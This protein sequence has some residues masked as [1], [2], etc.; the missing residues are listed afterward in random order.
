MSKKGDFMKQ[1]HDLRTI[2][3]EAKRI[4]FFGGAGVSKGS[5]IPDFRGTGG[6][7]T[8]GGYSESP[9]EMLSSTYL[10][11]YP[12]KFF[13]YYKNN[14]LYP[15]AKPNAA[16]LTLAK[17][18]RE[19][20]LTSVITQ[21]VDGLHQMAGSKNVIE[22]H[23]SVLRNYC[24]SCGEV[25]PLSHILESDGIPRCRLCGA[26]V[27]PD[28]VLYGEN[29]DGAAFMQAQEDIACADVLI[30][31]GTSLTVYPAAGLVQHFRGEH[32][33][34]INQT[35]TPYD[36]YAEIIIREPIEKVLADL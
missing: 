12:E 13:A 8:Q 28:V 15:D 22:L 27:R 10:K 36:S 26:V 5:G 23:G 4:V 14:M 24:V 33:I 2:I 18:E 29:L 17:W 21:N 34:I 35:R 19:G 32:F 20:K 7:Y 1:E 6:L 30:V 16:H 11:R 25:H 9:E 31:G 3:K